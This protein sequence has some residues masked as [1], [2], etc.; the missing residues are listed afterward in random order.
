MEDSNNIAEL[1]KSNPDFRAVFDTVKHLQTR[2]K[3][4]GVKLEVKLPGQVTNNIKSRMA[5]PAASRQ[6]ERRGSSA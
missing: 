4:A 5:F 3:R 1:G 6:D 2:E